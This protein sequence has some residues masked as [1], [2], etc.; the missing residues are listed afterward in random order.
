M[1]R[2]APPRNINFFSFQQNK[3][4]IDQIC[5]LAGCLVDCRRHVYEIKTHKKERKKT[6]YDDLNPAKKIE[7][8]F[9]QCSKHNQPLPM[10]YLQLQEKTVDSSGNQ[11]FYTTIIIITHTHY[12]I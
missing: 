2:C 6:S 3:K 1:C 7:C 12:I 5:W 11:R 10:L 4:S 8:F 9:F